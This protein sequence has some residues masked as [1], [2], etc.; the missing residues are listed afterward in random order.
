V[1]LPVLAVAVAITVVVLR[2]ANTSHAAS[3]CS[4]LY[5]EARSA[6]DTTRVDS[7]VPDRDAS[8]TPGRSSC[9][10]I[11]VNARWR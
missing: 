7:T 11:R 1:V 3:S 2:H 9:G 10:G 5:H 8:G 6:A 4:A